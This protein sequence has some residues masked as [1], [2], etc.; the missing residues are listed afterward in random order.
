MRERIDCIAIVVT[1]LSL[2]KRFEKLFFVL[3]WWRSG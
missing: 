3:A 2:S 1:T